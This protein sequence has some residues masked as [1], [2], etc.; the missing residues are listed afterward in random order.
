MFITLDQARA[1]D[2]LARHGTFALAAKALHKAHT[3]VLYAIKQ[4]ETQTEL[5]L[6]DRSAYRSR[7]TPAGE[8][9]LQR[10]RALLAEERK[11]LDA[12]QTLRSGWEPTLRVVF[13]AVYPLAPLLEVVRALR[14]ERAPTRFEVTSDSL[15]GVERRFVQDDAHAM[16]T[17]LPVERADLVKVKLRP[18]K[19]QLVAAR[20]HAL[21]TVRGAIRP[22]QLEGHVLVTVQGSDP[23]LN[24]PTAEIDRQSLVR[25][26]DFHTKKAALVAGLGFGW[27][28]DWLMQ[29]ELRRGAL[30]PLR[31]AGQSSHRFEPTLYHRPVLG[32][33]GQRLV[34]A[35]VRPRRA[36]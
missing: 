16:V 28:P 26:P 13:D 14:E 27:L 31:L 21:A 2:A 33:S 30:V 5:T 29:D 25:V 34:D 18:L 15:A 35:L 23:R 9:V 32:P 8:A 19:A 24:L 6:L 17:V 12:C 3:A 10:C 11:L 22:E 1:L 36:R 4:L 20:E 7:L